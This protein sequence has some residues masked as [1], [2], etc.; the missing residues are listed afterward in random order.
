[1]LLLGLTGAS[2]FSAKTT[3]KLTAKPT[4]QEDNTQHTLRKHILIHRQFRM[5]AGM[6]SY[7]RPSKKQR[8]NRIARC[9]VSSFKISVG[10]RNAIVLNLKYKL[11]TC[12]LLKVSSL[13]VTSLP[14][15]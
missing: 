2:A 9:S 15:F 3:N 12:S 13:K 11:N 6:E 1:M 14:L 10:V 7:L 5:L 8:A 4:K